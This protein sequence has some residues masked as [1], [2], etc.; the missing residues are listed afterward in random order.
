MRRPQHLTLH[1]GA[2]VVEVR[3][4]TRVL[5]RCRFLDAGG[6]IAVEPGPVA[7]EPG[8]RIDADLGD[9][10]VRA[11]LL[12]GLEP[13]D[14]TYEAV[15]DSDDLALPEQVADPDMDEPLYDTGVTVNAQRWEWL[16]VFDGPTD[17]MWGPGAPNWR[18]VPAGYFRH[19]TLLARIGAGF[20]RSMTGGANVVGVMT[21]GRFHYSWRWNDG[22]DTGVVRSTLNYRERTVEQLATG[23]VAGLDE[24]LYQPSCPDNDREDIDGCEDSGW[25][26]DMTFDPSVPLDLVAD[27]LATAWRPCPTH[28]PTCELQAA[29]RHWTWRHG[30]WR[31]APEPG[32]GT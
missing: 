24:D 11:T 12:R 16:P 7:V 10:L 2:E 32:S 20:T 17:P 25:E 6:D 22:L 9:E 23:F 30:H 19:A 21:D 1:R 18:L 31:P 4:G 15:E 5:C 27:A 3:D 13:G 28:A 14:A 8:A 26:I 29:D